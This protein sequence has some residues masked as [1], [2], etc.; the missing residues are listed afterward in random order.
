LVTFLWRASFETWNVLV[1]W[2]PYSAQQPDDYKMARL[3]DTN[4]W[5]KTLRMPKGARF[6][7]Q[8]SPND[9]LTRAPNAQ[10]FATTQFDPLNPR[11]RPDDPN[12]T[13]YEVLSIAE[14]PGAP[15]QEWA[16][17][18]S[19]VMPGKIEKQRFKSALLNNERDIA[20]YTP[21]NYQPGNTLYDLLILFDATTYQTQV[22]APV[23]LDNLIAEKKIAPLV[24]VLINYPRPED[25]MRELSC[26][27]Q[28]ADFLVK[29]LLPWVRDRYHVARD[30]ARVT[31]G[32]LSGGGL[33]A[34]YVALRNPEAFGNVLAQ[35]GSFWWAPNRDDG[36][37]PNWLARQYVGS[38]QLQLRFYLEAGTFENDIIG[39][40]GQIL[41]TS[42]HL[43]DV[44]RAKGY[45][46][47]YREFVGGHDYLSWRGSLADGLLSLVRAQR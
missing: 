22:P 5:Y 16:N 31:V 11:R 33:A 43:R 9:T 8:L 6:L 17:R 25:R 36:E 7:Y 2:T 30:P 20:I 39:A 32:G 41:E 4:L 18:R 44:L 46:V 1:V 3:A 24:A 35:S 26:N 15:P 27:P 29:E 14:L 38:P 42:R 37:E 40:G 23:I 13:K 21:A 28:F 47:Q 10:R 19:D 34:A 12:I 45:E